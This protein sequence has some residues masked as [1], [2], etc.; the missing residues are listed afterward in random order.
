MTVAPIGPRPSSYGRPCES[1]AA[2]H[3]AARCVQN[4]FGISCICPFGYT[5]DG[6]GHFGCVRSNSTFNV[7][8]SNP[9]LNGGTCTNVGLFGFRCECPAGT[10]SPRCLLSPSG[11]A[12][13]PC[14]SGGTCIPGFGNAYRCLCPPGRNGRNCQVEVRTCGGVLNAANG[15]LKY[16]LSSVYPHNS[17]C[18]WLIK[19][20]EDKVLNVTFKRFELERSRDCRFDWL[21]IHDGRSS[22]SYMIGRFCGTDLPMNG[23][24]VTT[25]NMLYLWFRSDNSSSHAGF[26]LTWNTT[27]PGMF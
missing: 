8:A 11:C 14:Q 23:N 17:R 25:Q 6:F 1:N 20:D 2:C 27:T 21:Q 9:C 5:G 15:T 18:A 10:L 7:C 22:A 4:V 19:T 16:P 24:I 12:S 13:N 26:E 3:P